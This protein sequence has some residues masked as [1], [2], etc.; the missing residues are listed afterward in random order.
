MDFIQLKEFLDFKSE[1]Y[2]NKKFLTDDP[3]QLV[4]RF[5]KKEDQE[6][7]G[8]LISTIAW[9]NRKSIISNGEKLIEIMQDSP[10][11]FVLNYPSSNQTPHFV[12]RTFNATD[13]DFFLRALNHIYSTKSSLENCFQKHEEI[14]GIKGR[15]VSFREQFLV[16]THE[17]RSEKHISNPLQN[18]A[19]KRLN[20][21]LRWMVRPSNKGVDLG[22]WK[23]IAPA[24][25]YLPLDV[26]TSRNARRLGLLKRRQDDWKALNELMDLLKQFDPMDPV[27]YDFA[28]FG[29][30]VNEKDLFA[31]D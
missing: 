24:E 31:F 23:S 16:T 5:S 6:I 17:R 11:E 25:L 27:K 9:G 22:I 4:H 8:F 26:H 14:P 18:S 13:L 15:I 19:C 20:M 10:H 29:I 1:Q 12:H 2:E 28:L 21:F 30:G 3:I 7:I